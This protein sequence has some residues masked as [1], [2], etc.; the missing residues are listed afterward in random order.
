M[1]TV[2]ARQ[3]AS[4][5]WQQLEEKPKQINPST[6]NDRLDYAGRYIA[7]LSDYLS[8]QNNK[9]TIIEREAIAAAGNRVVEILSRM[10]SIE[11]NTTFDKPKSLSNSDTRAILELASPSN[12]LNPWQGLK[13][14]IRNFAIICVLLDT[15][16]RS[17]ELLSL[18]LQDIIFAKMGAKGLK[19]RRRQGSKD[20]PRIN[21]PS[22][23]RDEREVPL[24]ESAF[25][26][27]NLY[28]TEVRNI[29]P[30]SSQTQY[31]FV[32]LS[33]H[34]VGVP[35]SSITPI[36]D[37]IRDTTGIN[38]TPHVLRHTATWRFCTAQKKL[39]L[40]WGDFVEQLILKF[41][42]ANE[43][44]PSVRHYAKQFLKDQMFETAA[45][46]QSILM[47]QMDLALEAIQREIHHD[48]NC[49]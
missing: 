47:E 27:L 13:T 42:W 26:A 16:L 25:K 48:Y 39:G 36:T 2:S 44:S 18:K 1:K 49:Q 6:Y 21:Q 37:K 15:G 45:R 17:G 34:K 19:V 8:D 35:L 29:I 20:D 30:E 33:N 10:K 12:P 22:S 5:V 32:S 41:G 9:T 23:K 11:P 3:R 40:K 7:W 24:S 43:N 38:L 31:L 14:R 28:V 4:N 46:E